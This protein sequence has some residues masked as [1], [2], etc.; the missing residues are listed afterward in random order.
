MFK[1][2][3][4]KYRKMLLDEHER[5]RNEMKALEQDV[6]YDD[7]SAGQNELADYDQHP[8][9]DATETFF[10]ERDLALIDSF[11]DTIGRIDEALGKIDRGTYGTCDRCGRDIPKERLNAVPEAIYCV[12]CQDVVEAT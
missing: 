1:P 4:E 6:T 5:I 8:A 9:D 10:K 3:I 7:A 11:R 12:E 2:N